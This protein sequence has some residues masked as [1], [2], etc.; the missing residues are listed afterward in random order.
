MLY[1]CASCHAL[2]RITRGSTKRLS[3]MFCTIC[4]YDYHED[5]A[6]AEEEYSHL[7]VDIGGES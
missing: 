7:W 4:A 1:L 2:L 6:N 5:F 3:M